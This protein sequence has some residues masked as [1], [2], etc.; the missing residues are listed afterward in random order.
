MKKI[1]ILGMLASLLTV[2][3]LNAQKAAPAVT[4][5]PASEPIAATA[6]AAVAAN[7]DTAADA[8]VAADTNAVASAAVAADAEPKPAPVEDPVKN[9]IA[10]FSFD[11]G[12]TPDHA[13]S[14]FSIPVVFKR[15]SPAFL[16][17]QEI[18]AHVP[19]LVAGKF[20]QGLLMESAHANLCG[21][22]QAGAVEASVFQ[23]LNGSDLTVTPEQPWEGKQ[24]LAVTTR[25]EAGEEGMALE[26]KAEKALY[27]LASIVPA[28]YV[29][30][31][32]LKGQGNLK[33]FLKDMDSDTSGEAVYVELGSEWK[34]FACT[35][36]FQ[37]AAKGIGAKHAAD[38]KTLL[39]PGTNI[40]V[41]L[42]LAIVTTD[43][44]KTTFYAD[45]L[46][47]EQLAMPYTGTRMG[48]SP[49][50]WI[51]GDTALANETIQMEIKSDAFG[52][53]RKNGTISFWFLPN[54]EARDGTYDMIFQIMPGLMIL[55]HANGKLHLAPAGTAFTPSDWQNAW[56]HIAITWNE[57]GHWIMYVDGLD[58]PN[59]EI[60]NRPLKAATA[61][62]FGNADADIVPN[63][64]I[65][66]LMLFQITLTADQVRALFAGEL[67]N[68]AVT[69][70]PPVTPAKMETPASVVT[71][72][73][74]VTAVPAAT[75]TP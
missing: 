61:L 1:I 29:A 12:I 59:D 66:D 11:V 64:V 32:Y 19:R 72:G 33:L 43:S 56:H 36:G 13:S 27:N 3:L 67:L 62:A 25:G 31:V 18:S 45:G 2:G 75:N 24:A 17:G 41:R 69:T 21:P 20:G 73:S 46:Q 44:L 7:T 63:G 6:G 16:N 14:G 49:H 35:F 51:P 15:E 53:W 37:F 23:P 60:M 4:T 50:A 52:S 47:V 39:P 38:W 71:T 22:I 8:A 74:V 40:A 48:P 10:R 30:S 70:A 65:D 28:Y 68:P 42:Q 34:R 26:L 9:M 57:E 55:R 54:W 5:A 58:Y